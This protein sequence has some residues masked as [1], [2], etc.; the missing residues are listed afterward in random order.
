MLTCLIP[1][2]TL[3]GQLYAWASFWRHSLMWASNGLNGNFLTKAQ[4]IGALAGRLWNLLEMGP[5]SRW[6][7]SWAWLRAYSVGLVLARVLSLL[8]HFTQMCQTVA[9]YFHSHRAPLSCYYSC[10][11]LYLLKLWARINLLPVSC[12]GYF[13]TGMRKVISGL[14]LMLCGVEESWNF[15]NCPQ[16]YVKGVCS[17]LGLAPWYQCDSIRMLG[18]SE[19]HFYN[20]NVP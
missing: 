5:C 3:P 11:E 2:W 6:R 1:L 17:N 9:S 10:T 13:A 8:S 16:R 14:R 4:C 18:L 7:A 15:N 12:V 19:F 20:L